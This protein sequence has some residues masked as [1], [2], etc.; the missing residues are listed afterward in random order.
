MKKNNSKADLTAKL[1]EILGK[2]RV[3]RDNAELFACRLL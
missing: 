1:R 2:D 3:P